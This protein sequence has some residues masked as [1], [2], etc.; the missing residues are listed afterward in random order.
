MRERID[1]SDKGIHGKESYS[2]AE[3]HP[4]RIDATC[5]Q[6]DLELVVIDRCFRRLVGLSY[7]DRCFAPRPVD[8]T[9]ARRSV[10]HA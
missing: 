5:F 4:S 3:A 8:R 9:R 10:S 1:S 6:E 2:T 7:N